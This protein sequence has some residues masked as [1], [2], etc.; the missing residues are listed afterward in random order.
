MEEEKVLFCIDVIPNPELYTLLLGFGADIRVLSP[1][2]VV[3]EMRKQAEKL[4]R[5]Y[6]ET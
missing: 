1:Q 2:R 5:V 3:D 4:Y 6:S